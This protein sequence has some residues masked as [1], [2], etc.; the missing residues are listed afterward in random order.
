MIMKKLHILYGLG[1]SGFGK[2]IVLGFSMILLLGACE[3]FLEVDLPQSQITGDLIFE[4]PILAEGALAEAYANLREGFLDAHPMSVKMGYYV[5][6]MIPRFPEND[7]ALNNTMIP[8]SDNP[9]WNPG[10]KLIYKVNAVIEGIEKSVN[11]ETE[12]KNRIKGEALFIKALVHFYLMNIH[13]AVPYISTTDYI[14]NTTVSRTPVQEVYDNII[15]DLKEAKGLLAEYS[16]GERVFVNKTVVSAFLARVYLYNEQWQNAADESN[17]LINNPNYTMEPDLSKVFLA[18][19]TSTILSLKNYDGGVAREAI[20]FYVPDAAGQ[21]LMSEDLALAFE[22]DDHR[23]SL[24]VG[25]VPDPTVP[26]T[27]DY[28]SAKY[29]DTQGNGITEY[30]ILFRIEEQYLIRAEAR[31]QLGDISGAQ[32]DLNMIR[33]RAGLTNT[34]AANLADLKEAL[35][36]E[37]RSELFFEHGHRFFDL[38]RMGFAD[39]VLSLVKPNWDTNDALW[40]IPQSEILANPNLTQNPGYN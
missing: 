26:G 24:W 20:T 35:L 36:K 30:S 37:R 15:A 8:T 32:D 34:T 27:L 25:N 1:K 10:Y 38:K 18:N 13:G 19:S 40:P 2:K 6:E 39:A 22:P 21:T 12:L 28:Y 3:S 16:S 29:K 23:D 5:D 11:L 14:T 4:D 17:A 31:A 9:F 33:N 7:D